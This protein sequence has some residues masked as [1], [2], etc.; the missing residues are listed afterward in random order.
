MN[1]ISRR[2]VKLP[3]NRAELEGV[4]PVNIDLVKQVGRKY[5]KYVN[6][7][8][9]ALNVP[10]ISLPVKERRLQSVMRAF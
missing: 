7:L 4:L 6:L 1:I 5:H 9:N 8:F 3:A 2:I 10:K